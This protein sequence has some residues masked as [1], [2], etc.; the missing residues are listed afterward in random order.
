MWAFDLFEK[1]FTN[2]S[3]LWFFI[4]V[5]AFLA[6]KVSLQ[7]LFGN[8]KILNI[9]LKQFLNDLKYFLSLERAPIY[10]VSARSSH[11]IM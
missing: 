8:L 3:S 4:N 10:A 5:K 2:N 1:I 9:F 11:T 6:Q 7:M